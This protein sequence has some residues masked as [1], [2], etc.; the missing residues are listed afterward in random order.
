MSIVFK[1]IKDTMRFMNPFKKFSLDE[2]PLEIRYDPL[3]GQTTRV[4]DLPYRP[5]ERPD[6]KELV[7]KLGTLFALFVLKPLKNRLPSIQ[8][9][10]SLMAGFE[11]GRHAWSPIFCPLTGIRGSVSSLKNILLL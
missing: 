5:P 11:W 10:L 6:F 4:F 1:K 2:I 9:I 8:K 7:K 3:T